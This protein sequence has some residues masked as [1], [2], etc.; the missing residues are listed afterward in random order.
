MSASRIVSTSEVPGISPAPVSIALP[1]FAA[2]STLFFLALY[3][4]LPI[5]RR[6]GVSWFVTFNLVLVLPM[7]LLGAAALA[8]C[9]LEGRPFSWPA[10]RDRLRLRRPD[11]T[12]W[13]WTLALSA[14][15]YGGRWFF[16]VAFVGALAAAAAEEGGMRRGWWKRAIGLALFL[17]L[18]WAL[19]QT[20]PWLERVRLHEKPEYLKEFLARFGPSDFMGIPLAGRWWVAAYYAAVLLFCNVLGEELWW[21]GYLLPR[22]E[23]SSGKVAWLVHGSLWAAFHLFFQWTLWDL[24]RMVPTCCALSFVAQHRRNT[25]PE[26]VAHTFGNSAL[27]L[28]IMRGVMR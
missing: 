27:L 4:G 15:M 2:S 28:Q 12:T 10:L 20:G 8:G 22:Q 19:W 5:L 24:V 14:F 16:A 1:L 18:S 9:R 21:R 13:L 6:A 25:W 17:T 3:V 11:L 7:S 23:L 26:I